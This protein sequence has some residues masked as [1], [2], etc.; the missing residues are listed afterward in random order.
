MAL[1]EFYL[2]SS[3]KSANIYDNMKLSFGDRQDKLLQIPRFPQ[4]MI[5]S[6]LVPKPPHESVPTWSIKDKALNKAPL[7]R[8]I[9]FS[10]GQ[11]YKI[12]RANDTNINPL[13]LTP[14]RFLI[15]TSALHCD[16]IQ[17]N[18]FF[19][20]INQIIRCYGF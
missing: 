15:R 10:E 8:F 1:Y 7:N 9:R 4:L 2:V 6:L 3:Y 14:I 16:C 19:N 12:K 18:K 13:N 17:A 5:S 20:G 11:K